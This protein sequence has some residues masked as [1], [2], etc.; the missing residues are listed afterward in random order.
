MKPANELKN[1]FQTME[2][3]LAQDNPAAFDA[4]AVYIFLEFAFRL[5]T[6][7]EN[8]DAKE[9]YAAAEVFGKLAQVK[10]TLEEHI[11]ADGQCKF[12]SNEVFAALESARRELMK[13]G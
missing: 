8:D 5:I 3:F 4:K 11:G 1:I 10:R 7:T 12:D 6:G 2:Q 9:V 13:N